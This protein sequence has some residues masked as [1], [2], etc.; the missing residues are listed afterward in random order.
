MSTPESTANNEVAGAFVE[1]HQSEVIGVLHGWDRLRLQGTLRSLYY[2]PVMEEYLWQSKVLWK[3]FK[4]FATDLTGRVRGAAEKLAAGQRRPMIYLPSSRTRKEQVAREIQQRDE[5]RRGLIAVLS[6]VE[7]CHTWFL[8]GNRQTQKLELKLQWG[9]CMHLYFYW[10]HEDLGF[11]HLRL[12]SWFPFLI[13]VCVNGR[14]GSEGVRVKH[15]VNKNSLKFYDKGSVLRVEATINEPKDFRSFRCA[16][17]NPRSAKQWRI[18]RRSVADFY[19][20][21]EVSRAATERHLTALA[22][23]H[24]QTPLKEQAAGVCR[25]VRHNTQR[26]R[27]LNPLADNDARLMAIV[28]RGEFSLNGFRNRDVRA[29]LYG[30]SED[31]AKER[32]QMARVGRQ[33]RLLR[34]HGL[35][36]KVSK[37][38]RYV[39]TQKGR[40][41][42]TALLAARQASTEK[43]TALAA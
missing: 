19:R 38:H 35:I 25:S 12:Q 6:C 8:R 37:T 26:Y 1:R 27:A 7:P 23:V 15:W 29:H 13:Q 31:K 11:L 4:R 32:R 17:H 43:L 16:E 40:N 2:Q 20:R 41:V 3:D 28:N 33:L 30:A 14:R 22:S 9:K 36:A 42:I 34:A 5:V 18:L 10:M 21:A 39:V 24:V